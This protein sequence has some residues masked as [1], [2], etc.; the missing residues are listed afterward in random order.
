M[1][2]METMLG[3]QLFDRT[4]RPAVISEHGEALGDRARKTVELHGSLIN[5]VAGPNNRP[6]VLHVGAVHSTICDI[7]P[8]ALIGMDRP[9]S[10]RALQACWRL[11]GRSDRPCR[12]GEFDGAVV[13]A[14]RAGGGA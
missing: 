1:R 14:P 12:G 13:S 9:V 2:A 10:W 8:R 5:D 3:V 6:S 7:V 11:A 4:K